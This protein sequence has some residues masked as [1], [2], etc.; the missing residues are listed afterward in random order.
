MRCLLLSLSFI[1]SAWGIIPAPQI[2]RE[3]ISDAPLAA[4]AGAYAIRCKE[5]EITVAS[6]D[7]AGLFYAQQSLKHGASAKYEA[8]WEIIDAPRY[9]WRGLHLDV[10]RHFMTVDELKDFISRMSSLKLN[11]LHLHLTDGP[12]WRLEI[13]QYPRLT[14]V[15]AWRESRVDK[16]WDWRQT[17]M[18]GELKKP[19]GG[20]YTQADVRELIAYAREHHVMIV[21]E[22]D[23]PGH[24]YAAIICYPELGKADFEPQGNGLRGNDALDMSKP[25]SLQFAKNVLTEVMDMFPPDTPIHLGG[26]EVNAPAAQQAAWMQAL[27]D[28]GRAHGREIICWDEAAAN[29]VRGITASLWRDDQLQPLLNAGV[30]LIL[31]HTSHFYFDFRQRAGEGEPPAMGENVV[32]LRQVFEYEPHSSPL[33]MGLQ[34]NVWTEHMP[35]Y[36]HVLYMAFPR[37]AAVAE[38]AWGSPR[39]PFEDFEADCAALQLL[40]AM[41]V[42]PA[43]P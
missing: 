30:P 33:I 32:T 11:R 10:S 27:V 39:R 40:P 42:T 25:Q 23:F 22:L 34:G 2:H 43:Q 29:G 35:T 19:Y 18:G 28:F 6:H 20:F 37:A 41:P 38:R 26:D 5:G 21:P 36:A 14:S 8:D 17:Q 13:K 12:G 16:P 1:S 9:A 15:G 24:S 31:C 7:E 4:V 3:G